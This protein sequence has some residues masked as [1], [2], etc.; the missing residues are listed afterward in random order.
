MPSFGTLGLGGIVAFVIGSVMLL[1]NDVP[2]FGIAW[3][4]IAGMGFA[5]SL[6]LLGIVSFAVRARGSGPS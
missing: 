6:L 3:Q 5:G 4:L 1:D 2:G